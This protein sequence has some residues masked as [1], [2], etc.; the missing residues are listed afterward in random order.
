M[1]LSSPAYPSAL[2]GRALKW[3]RPPAGF[4]AL[5]PPGRSSCERPCRRCQH[6]GARA[7]F[8]P[9]FLLSPGVS[10]DIPKGRPGSRHGGQRL[11]LLPHCQEGELQLGGTP[12]QRGGQGRGR[13]RAS[14]LLRRLT[15]GTAR[16]LSVSPACRVSPDRHRMS[17]LWG[18]LSLRPGTAAP[19]RCLYRQRFQNP[20]VCLEQAKTPTSPCPVRT[21]QVSAKSQSVKQCLPSPAGVGRA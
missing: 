8:H 4:L 14:R 11:P 9:G 16:F 5:S 12:G 10:G 21:A 3:P 15:L 17:F 7:L 18:P 1:G 2:R 13:S 19:R 20:G 6:R